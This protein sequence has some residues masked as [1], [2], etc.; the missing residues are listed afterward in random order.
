MHINWL[1]NIFLHNQ[2]NDQNVIN[3]DEEIC[4]HFCYQKYATWDGELYLIMAK[5]TEKA[6]LFLTPFYVSDK[7]LNRSWAI[8]SSEKKVE[9]LNPQLKS[10]ILS[11][12][13]ATTLFCFCSFWWRKKLKLQ[14]TLPSQSIGRRKC[15][16]FDE[17]ICGHFCYQKNATWDDEL[18]LIL[19]K[20][21]EKT[22]LFFTSF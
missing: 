2:C 20:W 7:S 9:V 22:T 19:T 15:D 6:T 8:L 10:W 4:G 17:E 13:T 11:T 14:M 18:H 16:L 5:K 1:S 21:T 12:Y 3:F